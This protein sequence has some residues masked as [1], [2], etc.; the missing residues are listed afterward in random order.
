[1]D[2]LLQKVK[3]ETI[4][5]LKIKTLQHAFEAANSITQ[6]SAKLIAY[7]K[8]GYA[9]ATERDSTLFLKTSTIGYRLAEKLR[10]TLAM[11]D[12]H[13]NY[14]MYYL[15][16]SDYERSYIHYHNAWQ[17]FE[18]RNDYYA[19]KM[20]Y[21]MAYI[22]GRIKDY[23]GAEKLLFEAIPIF[24]RLKKDKQ[25]YYC[26]NH[27]GA[28]YENLKEYDEA[29]L[30]YQM[31]L[32]YLEHVTPATLYLQDTRN[33]IGL[34]YQKLG[35]QQTAI[36]L[37]TKALKTPNLYAIDPAL[38][39]RLLDNKTYSRFL[40]GNSTEIEKSFL[41]AL[42]IRD[43]LHHTA[44]QLVSHLHLARFYLQQQDSTKAFAY[45]QQAYTLGSE[46]LLRRDA[47]RALLLLA[48]I[49]PEQKAP[50]LKKHIALTKAIQ[51]E[52]RQVRQKFTKIQFETERYIEENK[53]LLRDKIWSIAAGAAISVI[54]ILLFITFRQR[55]KNKLLAFESQ[56]QRA[57]EQ[58]YLLTLKQQAN[59][60]KGRMEERR[61]IAEDLH[62]GI[63]ARL[64]GMRLN[65][66]FLR[67]KG[68]PTILKK[69]WE[70]L[71]TLQEIEG[72]IRNLSHDLKHELAKTDTHYIKTLETL[73]DK[74]RSLGGFTC[75]FKAIPRTHWEALDSYTKVN[76]YRVIE[77][78]L[79]NVTKHA[80]ATNVT[81]K[82]IAGPHANRLE[83]SDNG[84]GFTPK[85]TTKG[86][87]IKNMSSRAEKINGRFLM[88]SDPDTGTHIIITFPKT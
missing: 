10:D 16:Q 49:R 48:E 39:A 85:F 66:E 26:Y 27:L 47:L 74:W 3:Y 78:A 4:D 60:E 61:R 28:I 63:L 52:E 38:Y 77:E 17:F 79:H 70:H 56:Q 2:S 80:E 43:S 62:D 33:N 18:N 11:A 67:V 20:L 57:N 34:L 5:T 12:I 72:D 59:L 40:Q 36:A 30:H 32:D 35:Q 46:T 54:L 68:T 82:L 50:Y 55:A 9:A 87:G 76:L 29:L 65:W 31:A 75:T 42:H 13:W 19:G 15:S 58:I 7:T 73:V 25:L 84:K 44:G 1:V 23:T 37:F 41:K 21:N 51:A 53:Q 86:I 64:F 22:T 6:D 8:L 88:D 69:H 83:I 81:V 14:G 71:T 45:A 24:E